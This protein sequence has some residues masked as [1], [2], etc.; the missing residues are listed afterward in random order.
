MRLRLILAP[1]L[2]LPLLGV[3]T[4][5]CPG[6]E[7]GTPEMKPVLLVMDVQ[8][9]WLP[10]M[11]EE[12]RNAAPQKI[13]EAISLF[14]EFGYPVIRVYHSHPERGPE[15]DTEPFEFLDSI[16]ITDS[17]RRIVKAH[18]SAFTKTELEQVLMEGGHNTVFLCGLSATGCVLATYFGALEREFMVLMVE[19]TLLSNDASHTKVI[20]DICYSVTLEELKKAFEEE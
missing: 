6:Q 1:L 11:A 13:N 18:A 10:L 7:P 15:L 3:W 8:N 9:T 17:D 5:S 14:R 4:H 16:A 12:D 2:L 20:E 19:E